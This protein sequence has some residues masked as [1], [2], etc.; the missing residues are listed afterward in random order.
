MFAFI[1]ILTFTGQDSV[2]RPK[3]NRIKEAGQISFCKVLHASGTS[4][5][6][7]DSAITTN[8]GKSDFAIKLEGTRAQRFSMRVWQCS[9]LLS[10]SAAAPCPEA[11]LRRQTARR[12]PSSGRLPAPA[13]P[14]APRRASKTPLQHPR[15]MPTPVFT[16]HRALFLPDQVQLA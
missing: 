9:H 2:R 14:I 16:S 5:L 1:Q 12:L 4:T 8:G 11:F 15:L 7:N 3:R 13:T 6:T 10:P